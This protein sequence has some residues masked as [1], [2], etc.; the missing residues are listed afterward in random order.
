MLRFKRY[1]LE[2]FTYKSS[3]FTTWS[4]FSSSFEVLGCGIGWARLRSGAPY[5][6]VWLCCLVDS[7]SPRCGTVPQWLAQAAPLL[8]LEI[9]RFCMEP[10]HFSLTSK[11][12]NFD[13]RTQDHS[14]TFKVHENSGVNWESAGLSNKSSTS[15]SGLAVYMASL[16][17]LGLAASSPNVNDRTPWIKNQ[18]DSLHKS[19][20]LVVFAALNFHRLCYKNKT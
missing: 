9:S 18:K 12:L 7:W 14:R 5:M 8:L 11:T 20:T 3:S 17:L 19:I 4:I 16:S 10:I 6:W 15:I 2:S 1:L 13:F